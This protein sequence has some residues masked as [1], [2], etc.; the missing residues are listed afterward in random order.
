MKTTFIKTFLALTFSLIAQLAIAQTTIKGTVVDALSSVFISN[1]H[2]KLNDSYGEY[3][4]TL[5]IFENKT[6]MN[7]IA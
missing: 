2:V 7:S 5:L 6:I 4:S 3:L 1:A